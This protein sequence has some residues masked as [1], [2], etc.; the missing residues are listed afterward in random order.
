MFQLSKNELNYFRESDPIFQNAT[1]ARKY[2]PYVL[3]ENG[4]AALTGVLG[5][6]IVIKVNTSIFRTFVQMRKLLS[7]DQSLLQKIDELEKGSNKL[8]HLNE[9]DQLRK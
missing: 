7:E 6:K 9:S 8:F 4:I 1:H 5:S 3:T 2:A